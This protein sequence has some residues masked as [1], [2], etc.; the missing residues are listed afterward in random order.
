MKSSSL[1]LQTAFVFISWTM[2]VTAIAQSI[3]LSNASTLVVNA[4]QE[5][6]LTPT[7]IRLLLPI[8]AEGRE[9]RTAIT[10]LAEHRDHVRQELMA[11]KAIPE[12]ISFTSSD[13]KSGIPGLPTNQLLPQRQAI[14]QMQQMRGG[15]P[16]DLDSLPKVFTA[17]ALA[18]ADWTIPKQDLD[19]LTL[20]VQSLRE[21][22]FQRDLGGLKQRAELAPDERAKLDEIKQMQA[23]WPTFAYSS[24][25]E[26]PTAA[27]IAF[28][29][30]L[31]EDQEAAVLKA[32]MEQAKR[33]ATQM[34]A[35][36]GTKLGKVRS[37]QRLD[38]NMPG[39]VSFQTVYSVPTIL[40]PDSLRMQPRAGETLH[41]QS[42]R[43][44]KTVGMT[45]VF[46]V[47]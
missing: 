4:H 39:N 27:Q 1:L 33:V 36:A 9:A 37:L 47:E 11:L 21:Q 12:S 20:A 10:K 22:I 28:V 35:A 7:K 34:A 30:T 13:V 15:R 45:V 46:D 14:M 40:T 5:V 19:A 25:Q 16:L 18:H 17:N 2:A 32:V 41:A 43:L 31:A 6:K 29:A 3:P 24:Q 26:D 42:D 44:S 23:Q 38:T 8:Q